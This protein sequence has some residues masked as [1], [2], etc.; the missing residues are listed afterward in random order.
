MQ[1]LS[2]NFSL[3]ELT[4]SDIGERLGLDNTPDKAVIANLTALCL[5][6]LQPLRD[7]IGPIHVNSGYRSLA[8]NKAVKGAKNSQH[9]KGQAA[10][11][12]ASWMD[13]YDLAMYIAS[14]LDYDEVILEC[15]KR[16]QKDSGWV[17]VS[18]NTEQGNRLNQLTAIRTDKGIVYKPGLLA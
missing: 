17:H 15:Y 12:E 3:R 13:N 5:E 16:G 7:R 4:K 18:Y 8:V 1:L 9:M 10:D 2:P 11:I 6:V 14:E